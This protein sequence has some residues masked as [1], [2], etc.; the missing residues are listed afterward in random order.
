MLKQSAADRLQLSSNLQPRSS[1]RFLIWW[2]QPL[3][4][5]KQWLW[6]GV[7]LC[8]AALGFLVRKSEALVELSDFLKTSFVNIIFLSFYP[9]INQISHLHSMPA[10][11]FSQV[12]RLK[13]F[14]GFP[15][16]KGTQ[17]HNRHPPSWLWL[18]TLV[19]YF[20]DLHTR[21]TKPCA[22]ISSCKFDYTLHCSPVG[23]PQLCRFLSHFCHCHAIALI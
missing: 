3:T 15:T 2:V 20:L 18:V 4:T 7:S 21:Q 14:P 9:V 13:S 10:L 5:L 11:S 1:G 23:D 12:V 6:L 16:P 22:H 8:S 19:I 17:K